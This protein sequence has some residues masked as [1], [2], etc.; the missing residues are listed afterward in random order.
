[1]DSGEGDHNGFYMQAFS[2]FLWY[3]T[4]KIHITWVKHKLPSCIVS[5]FSGIFAYGLKVPYVLS[6]HRQIKQVTERYNNIKQVTHSSVVTCFIV[7]LS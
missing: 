1:M 2:V 7:L 6:I 5:D 4:W 3:I